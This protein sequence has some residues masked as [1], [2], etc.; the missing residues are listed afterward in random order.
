MSPRPRAPEDAILRTTVELIA[1]HGVSGVTVD[2]VAAMAGVGK[3]TIYRRWGSRARLVHA[4]IQGVQRPLVEPDTGS[5]RD[6][7]VLLLRQLVAYLNRPDSGMVFTSFVDA[8]A[9]DPELQALRRETERQ[10]RA[11]YERVI[12]RGI[13]RGDLPAD[14]DVQLLIDLLISPFVYRRVLAQ[15]PVRPG[16]IVPLVDVV[17]GAFSRVPT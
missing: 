11:V 5:L 3:A 6:D 17:L 7:L 14:V 15:S 13:E 4:A 12:R 8:S 16:D 10:G 2:T 1:E 9:R